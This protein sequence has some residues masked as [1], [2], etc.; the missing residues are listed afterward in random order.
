[1]CLK[2]S[3]LKRLKSE[4]QEIR[5]VD[6]NSDGEDYIAL[7]EEL[8]HTAGILP[9]EKVLVC[10]RMNGARF[11]TAVRR[12][13]KGSGRCYISGPA[14]RL[15]SEGD[16]IAVMAFA[17]QIDQGRDVGNGQRKTCQKNR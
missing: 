9:H 15:V 5:V 1:M 13:E 7:D 6:T 3:M 2:Q 4:I 11:E 12:A 10:N 8:L 17:L 14:V 16:L